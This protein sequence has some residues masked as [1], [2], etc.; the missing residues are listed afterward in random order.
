MPIPGIFVELYPG[1][2]IFVNLILKGIVS[3]IA[4]LGVLS[5]ILVI[6]K[7]LL[8][9]RAVCTR[10]LLDNLTLAI[11]QLRPQE[12]LPYPGQLSRQFD[13]GAEKVQCQKYHQFEVFAIQ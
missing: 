2:V 7:S 6:E 8:A 9:T 12:R 11:S 5:S 10:F 3:S 13:L 4:T 1:T